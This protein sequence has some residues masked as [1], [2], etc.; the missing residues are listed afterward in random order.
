MNSQKFT[1]HRLTPTAKIKPFDCNIKDLNDFLIDDARDYL[2]QLLAVTY[3]LDTEINTIAY[4]S[5][6]NDSIRYEDA[7]TKSQFSKI[8]K[9]IPYKKR[10]LKTIPAVKIG[11]FA[12][13]NLYQGKGIGSELMN[14]IKWLFIDKNKTGCRYIV[15]DARNDNET[16]EFYKK[17]GFRMFKEDKKQKDETLF[18]YFDLMEYVNT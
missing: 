8:K 2:N 12:V 5:V 3:L 9:A 1:L 11:R 4:F 17:N 6:S 14:Y 7:P 13:N 15:V 18:M 10:G 16:I